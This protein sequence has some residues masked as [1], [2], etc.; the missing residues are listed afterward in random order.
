MN[1]TIRHDCKEFVLTLL[2]VNPAKLLSTNKCRSLFPSSGHHG[3]TVGSRVRMGSTKVDPAG[4]PGLVPEGAIADGDSDLVPGSPPANV[5][6][7][8]I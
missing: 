1:R 6:D 5:L 3:G 4:P 7:F 8:H 2:G